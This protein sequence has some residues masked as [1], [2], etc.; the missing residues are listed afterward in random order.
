MYKVW[1]QDLSCMNLTL[2]C[3]MIEKAHTPIGYFANCGILSLPHFEYPCF[4]RRP[5]FQR[6]SFFYSIKC[7]IYVE[8]NWP[9]DL[10]QNNTEL[11]LSMKHLH[12][13]QLSF[14]Y[15][16]KILTRLQYFISVTSDDL[17]KENYRI[18]PAVGFKH[19]SVVHM[20]LLFKLSFMSFSAFWSL[21]TSYEIWHH[22]ILHRLL[23]T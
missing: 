10:S 3:H 23:F 18:L 15:W 13:N 14:P 12:D 16:D 1:T 5:C 6:V 8:P 21:M 17:W 11:S 4:E 22:L 7:L 9:F 20:L 19:K 2:Y